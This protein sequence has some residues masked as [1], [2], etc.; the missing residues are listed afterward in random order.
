MK[1]RILIILNRLV[2]GGQSIDTIPLALQLKDRF[3]ILVAYGEKEN[4]ELL[5]D[6]A[7]NHT[8]ISFIKIPS[9]KRSLNP[10]EDINAFFKLRKLIRQYQPAIVHTHG[11]KPGLIGRPAAWFAGVKVIMHTMHGHIFHSYYNRFVSGII[12]SVE[13][14][15]ARITSKIV[16]LSQ[17]QQ[18]DI[19]ERYKIASKN[20]TVLIP[21]GIDEKLLTC[22][23]DELSRSS[24][25][26]YQLEDDE[27][28]ICIIGRMVPVKNFSFFIDII[29]E[30]Q[31]KKLKTKFFIIGDGIQKNQLQQTLTDAGITW[32]EKNVNLK[33]KVFFTSWVTPV[34]NILHGMDIVILTS[35]NEGTPM[36]IIEAQICKIPV[37]AVNT[38]GVKDTFINNE[39]GFLIKEHNVQEF[40]AAIEKLV[41]NPE[42]RQ[43]MGAK[44]YTFAA[45]K[46][47]KQQEVKAFTELYT[48]AIANANN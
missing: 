33:A 14:L 15:L 38:G 41:S 7:L 9:L 46:Y 30:M 22:N 35:F 26:L 16:V 43:N 3:E 25:S 10:L 29:I 34:T 6:E 31:A 48:S 37:V 12:I 36:S 39:T 44:G 42:L 18:A 24:R 27:T 32:S 11:S 4:D 21:L 23:A 8:E 2:I 20:N 5:Y 17:E 19:T 13:Q 28:A 1:P 40:A 47:S 45:S